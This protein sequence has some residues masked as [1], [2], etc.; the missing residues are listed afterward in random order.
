MKY[1]DYY[2]NRGSEIVDTKTY[3]MSFYTNKEGLLT[4]KDRIERYGDTKEYQ[5]VLYLNENIQ[6][7]G[8]NIQYFS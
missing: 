8:E 7:E 1:K 4:V 3:T 5:D 6:Y 2:I